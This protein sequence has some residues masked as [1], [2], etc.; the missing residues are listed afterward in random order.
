[1]KKSILFLAVVF[2]HLSVA[3][4]YEDISFD[5]FYSI[6]EV[7]DFVSYQDNIITKSISTTSFY[8]F[9]LEKSATDSIKLVHY[10]SLPLQRDTI[11]IAK[12]LRIDNKHETVVDIGQIKVSNGR[13]SNFEFPSLNDATYAIQ[14]LKADSFWQINNQTKIL[15]RFATTVKSGKLVDLNKLGQVLRENREEFANLLDL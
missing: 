6:E 2:P 13:Y 8:Q 15:G 9:L 11:L 5:A 12:C 14:Y 1:M 3:Q 4:V 10:I 7:Y